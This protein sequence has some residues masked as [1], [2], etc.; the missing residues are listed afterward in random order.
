VDR[1]VNFLYLN[2]YQRHI[3][4]EVS[5]IAHAENKPDVS[6]SDFTRDM[7]SVRFDLEVIKFGEFL[8]YPALIQAAY[9]K[10]VEQLLTR[11]RFTPRAMR[12]FVEWTHGTDKVCKDKQGLLKQLIVG[13]VIMHM[14][15]SWGDSQ[16]NEFLG[17]V[18]HHPRFLSG[19]MAA[20]ELHKKKL[21]ESSQKLEKKKRRDVKRKRITSG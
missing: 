19:V 20:K 18:E 12:D 17:L 6:Y 11:G 8:E 10:M 7:K 2:E 21:L 5:D 1:F 4:T 14:D 9:A 3:E 15:R 13:A 16:L